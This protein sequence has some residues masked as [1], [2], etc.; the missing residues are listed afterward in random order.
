MA[1]NLHYEDLIRTV[2]SNQHGEDLMAIWQ[3]MYGDQIS[4]VQG[5]SNEA[6]AYNEGHRA[7][8]LTIKTILEDKTK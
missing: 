2:F 1:E 4:F 3:R 6:V 7:F 8:Y 5:I